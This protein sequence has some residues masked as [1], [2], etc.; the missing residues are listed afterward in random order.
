MENEYVK[1]SENSFL[2][3]DMSN[4]PYNGLYFK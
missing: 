2:L 1:V 3:N 4:Q